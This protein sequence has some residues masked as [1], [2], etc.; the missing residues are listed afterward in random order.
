MH[1][2][3]WAPASAKSDDGNT[4]PIEEGKGEGLIAGSSDRGVHAVS[5]GKPCAGPDRPLYL[6]N[7]DGVR[8]Q[9]S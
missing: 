1:G 4:W 2:A 8:P 9:A 5:S 6:R 7:E 3:Q